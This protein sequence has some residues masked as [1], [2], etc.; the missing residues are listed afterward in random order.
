MIGSQAI[1]SLCATK[2]DLLAPGAAIVGEK[3][4]RLHFYSSTSNCGWLCIR[5]G[6]RLLLIFCNFLPSRDADITWQ[7]ER[8]LTFK[9]LELAMLPHAHTCSCDQ[10]TLGFLRVARSQVQSGKGA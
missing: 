6:G 10:Q 4:S 2:V 5:C 7:L 8:L 1:V 3:R 9:A